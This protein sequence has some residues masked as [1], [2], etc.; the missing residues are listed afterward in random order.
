MTELRHWRAAGGEEELGAGVVLWRGEQ[1]RERE[2]RA[3]VAVLR[4]RDR[5]AH[6]TGRFR[7]GAREER[8]LEGARPTLPTPYTWYSAERRA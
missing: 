3:R 8:V 1:H 2:E 5:A 6:L 7:K 4:V